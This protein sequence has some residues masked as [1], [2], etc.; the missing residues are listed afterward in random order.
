M[1]FSLCVNILTYLK[2][3]THTNTSP[4]KASFRNRITERKKKRSLG[5]FVKQTV[6]AADPLPGP[7]PF[8]NG[9]ERWSQEDCKECSVRELK[10]YLSI[11]T[12]ILRRILVL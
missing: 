12:V 4:G 10:H 7:L 2:I 3:Y 5:S 11:N 1:E 6:A 9:E 8:G